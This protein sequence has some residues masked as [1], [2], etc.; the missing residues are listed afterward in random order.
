VP[1]DHTVIVSSKSTRWGT[2]DPPVNLDRDVVLCLD[3]LA[4]DRG[5]LDLDVWRGQRGSGRGTT[6]TATATATPA[7][8]P[9]CRMAMLVVDGQGPSS[10]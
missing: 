7:L 1:A 9:Y 6:A 5:E 4:R 8:L 10:S 3:G 2:T